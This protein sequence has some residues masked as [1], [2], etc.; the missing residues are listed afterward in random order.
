MPPVTVQDMRQDKRGTVFPSLTYNLIASILNREVGRCFHPTYIT[1]KIVTVALELSS[2]GN[3]LNGGTELRVFYRGSEIGDV[4]YKEVILS[5]V[6][7]FM[8]M[9]K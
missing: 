5:H 2:D 7:L 9:K 1:D 6:R 3:M 8:D 4:Y